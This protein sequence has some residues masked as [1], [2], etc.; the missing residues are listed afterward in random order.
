[1]RIMR[2]LA[3]VLLAS[4]CGHAPPPKTAAAE[5]PVKTVA[6]VAGHWVT[7]DDMDWYYALALDPSGGLDLVIDRNKMGKCEQ[8][9]KL[10]AGDAPQTFLLTYERNECNRDFNGASVQVKIESFTGDSLTLALI[11]TGQ[12]RHR[13]TRDPKSVVQ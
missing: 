1:M 5:R 2:A 7:S 4:A 3:V 12:E 6:D 11:G 13:F 9:G 10:V 8:K